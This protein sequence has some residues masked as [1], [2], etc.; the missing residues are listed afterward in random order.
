MNHDLIAAG[1]P[2]LNF[3]YATYVR[4]LPPHWTEKDRSGTTVKAR[5]ATEIAHD[6]LVGRAATTAAACE[7]L[8]DRVGGAARKAPWPELSE[9]DCYACHHNL[10]SDV[11]PD[12]GH[13]KGRTPG[14]LVW[15]EPVFAG[16]LIGLSKNP[17]LAK[18]H[19]TLRD[20][21]HGRLDPALVAP[22]AKAAGTAWRTQAGTW[23]K[24]PPLAPG[25]IATA[26]Q[27]MTVKRWDDAAHGYYALRAL[28]AA[29]GT[30]GAEDLAGL[31]Q[32]VLLP[33]SRRD[34]DYN[35]PADFES[36]REALRALP[37]LFGKRR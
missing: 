23:A 30:E 4:A 7:L 37:A 2:R 13:F 32:A 27:G 19:Q 34:G 1:H 35:S 17:G 28:D 33:R 18:D 9:F 8:A 20:R 16:E 12:P 15:N 36:A 11:F 10:K 25:E 29:R 14:S 22:A 5:P 6:W 3:D 24:G 21:M 31:R 26:L